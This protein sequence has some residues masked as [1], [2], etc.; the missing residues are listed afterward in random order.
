VLSAIVARGIRP[1]PAENAGDQRRQDVK[2]ETAIRVDCQK[3]RPVRPLDRVIRRSEERHNRLVRRKRK[4]ETV[5]RNLMAPHNFLK[6]VHYQKVAGRV[7]SPCHRLPAVV[8][9]EVERGLARVRPQQIGDEAARW[10]LERAGDLCNL[11]YI[12]E[13]G[14]DSAMDAEDFVGDDGSEWEI[15][16]NLAEKPPNLEIQLRGA[17]LGKSEDRAHFGAFMVTPK[18]VDVTGIT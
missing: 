3:R 10:D 11:G 14:G 8:R 17:F 4:V 15:V 6:G 16:E 18:K 5:L 1:R 2:V 7:N 13:I 12:V 9:P